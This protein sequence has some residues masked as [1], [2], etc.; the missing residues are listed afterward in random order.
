L[1]GKL[2]GFDLAP[3][4]H[5]AKLL[6]GSWFAAGRDLPHLGCR[7]PQKDD[8]LGDG[9]MRILSHRTPPPISQQSSP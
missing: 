1:L 9:I 8:R 4:G 7:H 5:V 6:S 3:I 2:V